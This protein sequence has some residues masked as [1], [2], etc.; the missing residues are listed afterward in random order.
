M[1]L[2]DYAFKHELRRSHQTPYHAF[3]YGHTWCIVNDVHKAVLHGVDRSHA[4]QSDNLNWTLQ[5]HD[6]CTF[7]RKISEASRKP[8]I[9]IVID[10]V[11]LS[12]SFSMIN[13]LLGMHGE[14]CWVSYDYP[15]PYGSNL[16]H[17]LHIPGAGPMCIPGS[18]R[19]Y[20]PP[21]LCVLYGSIYVFRRALARH[22][23]SVCGSLYRSMLPPCQR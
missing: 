11:G 6:F 15:C 5:H 8:H 12:T 18:K 21:I 17:I 19:M 22:R 16:L 14:K 7:W 13:I 1:N 4:E 2:V 20:M 9:H 10:C 23:G 3:K